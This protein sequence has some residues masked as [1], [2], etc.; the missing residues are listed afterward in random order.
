MNPLLAVSDERSAGGDYH[1]LT[2][3]ALVNHFGS[4]KQTLF[5]TS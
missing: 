2:F 3:D 5:V 1:C 4:V